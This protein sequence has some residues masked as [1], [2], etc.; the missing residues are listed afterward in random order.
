MSSELPYGLSTSVYGLLRKASGECTRRLWTASYTA[1]WDPAPPS[2][3][4]SV[5]AKPLYY[6]NTAVAASIGN[7]TAGNMIMSYIP[8]NN[9]QEAVYA[10]YVDGELRKVMIINM[11]EYNS[12]GTFPRPSRTYTFQIPAVFCT[13]RLQ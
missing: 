10:S 13:I 7:Q 3:P 4:N 1:A 6:G 8:L 5:G 12:T 11:H 2:T 9:D